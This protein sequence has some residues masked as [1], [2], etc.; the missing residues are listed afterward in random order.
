MPMAPVI[1]LLSLFAALLLLGAPIAVSLGAAA[2]VVI[3]AWHLAP[4]P[5]VAQSVLGA[6]DCFTLLAIPLFILAGHILARSGVAQELAHLAQT[7]VGRL[8]G[9]LGMVMVVAGIFFAGCSGSGPADVA[10]LAAAL[11]PSMAAAG[12]GAGFTGALCATS[13]SIGIII[14][15]SIALI[16][17]GVVAEAS[18]SRLFMA[19]VLPGI[20]MGG[21]LMVATG[22][23]ASRRG[24]GKQAQLPQGPTLSRRV[25]RGLPGLLAPLVILGGIYGGVFTPTEAAAVVV[26]YALLLD[27]VIYRRCGLRGLGEVLADAGKASATVMFIVVCAGLFAWVL[28][29]QGAVRAAGE[30]LAALS[31]GRLLG[32]L[33]I[34]LLLLAAGCLLDPI[35]IYYIFTPILLPAARA[36]GVDPVHFGLIM[37]VNLAVAQ[38]TPPVGV[39]LF[40]ASAAAKVEL[41]PMVRHLWPLLLA[42][43]LTLALVTYVPALSLWLP[44]LLGVR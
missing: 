6:A 29:T 35:S 28:N 39:N 27:L 16:V 3:L 1:A 13:G 22:L 44:D 23:V 26:A 21:T 36:L 2:G 31:A 41:G 19:G 9:G 25:L 5:F 4:L 11:A 42:Q 17:Y 33:L 7:L 38:V 18:I 8:T 24:Y 14:P 20:L 37:T 15:P 12:Y 10:A 40:A 43:L 34:N 30:A 32:L